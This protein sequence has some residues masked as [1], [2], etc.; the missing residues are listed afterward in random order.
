MLHLP[1]NIDDNTL[2]RI[3]T[4]EELKQVLYVLDRR[5][6][7]KV[8]LAYLVNQAFFAGLSFYVDRRV[9]IPRSPMGELIEH[10]FSRGLSVM[11]LIQF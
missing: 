9:I 2:N 5:V 1:F 11:R 8:P 7:A 6:S 4:D 10:F 3:L